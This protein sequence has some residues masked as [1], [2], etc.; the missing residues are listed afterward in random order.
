MRILGGIFIFIGLADFLLSFVGINLTP[1]LPKQIARF[2]PIIFGL[3]GSFFL[4]LA[5]MQ[6]ETEMEELQQ[7]QKYTEQLEEVKKR[8]NK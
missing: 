7:P 5:S 4:K 6:E 3:I 1:F 8:K 2:T